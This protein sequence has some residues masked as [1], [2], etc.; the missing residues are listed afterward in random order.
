MALDV[1][2]PEIISAAL[3]AK[4]RAREVFTQDAVIDR[5]FLIAG[6]SKLFGSTSDPVI[7]DYVVGTAMTGSRATAGGVRVYKDQKKSTAFSVDRSDLTSLQTPEGLMRSTLLADTLAVQVATADSYIASLYT[8]A[9]NNLGAI[10][11]STGA[12]AANLIT[13]LINALEE[14]DVPADEIFVGVSPAVKNLLSQSDR[15]VANGSASADERLINGLVYGQK[16]YGAPV[17]VS[18]AIVES[19]SNVFKVMAWHKSAIQ[20][21]EEPIFSELVDSS[22]Q[23]HSFDSTIKSLWKYGA[24]VKNADRLAVATVTVS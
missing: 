20:M 23:S 16:I 4:M 9:G 12:D 21:V 10:T 15:V 5:E 22:T 13:D 2:K 1:L 19:S 8:D 17:L 3:E 11:I 14:N 18:N 6:D 7:E 24:A